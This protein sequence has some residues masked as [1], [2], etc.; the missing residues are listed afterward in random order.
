[1]PNIMILAQALLQIL[2]HKVE[3]KLQIS[4]GDFNTWYIDNIMGA[5]YSKTH[6]FVVG[7]LRMKVSPS[8]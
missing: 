2:V 8:Q 1:M 7:H 5:H 6:A 3:P 4:T